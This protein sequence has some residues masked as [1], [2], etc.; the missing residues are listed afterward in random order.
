MTT[1]I[2]PY[3]KKTK[4]SI[5]CGSVSLTKQSFVDECNI[6]NILAKY[7]KT[8]AIDHANNHSPNYGYA[9][10]TS[11]TDAMQIIAKGTN[12]FNDLPSSL[13][14]KFNHDPAE[15][16]E[17]TQNPANEQEMA[18]LGLISSPY[19]P[20]FEVETTNEASEETT[21]SESA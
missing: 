5:D 14:T 20:P 16:L 19:Q 12:M 13:R 3:G 11:F 10:S 1:I 15:F 21:E 8:G 7:Q 6:N 9:D 17:F 2:K 18:D 4:V